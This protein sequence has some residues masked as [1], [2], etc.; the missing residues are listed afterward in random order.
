MTVEAKKVISVVIPANCFGEEQ[1]GLQAKL[2]EIG[3]GQRYAWPGRWGP[4]DH[5]LL[6]LYP[7]AAAQS[8][9]LRALNPYFYEK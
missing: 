2:G 3:R 4:V 5:A 7:Q 1:R 8:E 9:E 6:M